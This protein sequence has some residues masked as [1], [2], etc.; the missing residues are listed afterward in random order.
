MEEMQK[1]NFN[2]G[3]V[4]VQFPFP[5]KYGQYKWTIKAIAKIIASDEKTE[6]EGR[7]ILFRKGFTTNGNKVK[8]YYKTIEF[9]DDL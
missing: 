6:A 4:E 3:Y 5:P 7:K 8:E 9:L 1:I 2:G